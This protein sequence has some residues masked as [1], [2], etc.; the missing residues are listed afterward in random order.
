[1]KKRKWEI[2]KQEEIFEK[3]LK[4]NDIEIIHIKE[5]KTKTIYGLK[6]NDVKMERVVFPLTSEMDVVSFTGII[7]STMKM[8]EE[9][10]MKERN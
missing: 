3:V 5:Y 9:M 8:L 10:N 2:S 1:M 6:R 7:I 4:E